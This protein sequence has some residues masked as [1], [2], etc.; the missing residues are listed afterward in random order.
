MR[1]VAD[2]T[3]CPVSM[4]HGLP[5]TKQLAPGFNSIKRDYQELRLIDVAGIRE[6]I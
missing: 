2:G 4:L 5:I 1:G 3:I 6:S